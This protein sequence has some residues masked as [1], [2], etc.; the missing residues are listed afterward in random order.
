MYHILYIPKIVMG[1]KVTL[2]VFGRSLLL[3]SKCRF[4]HLFERSI[5]L[6]GK[7]RLCRSVAV[8]SNMLTA[9]SCEGSLI[10]LCTYAQNNIVSLLQRL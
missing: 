4:M 10:R 1:E 2:K 6:N 5:S 9:S 8:T 3:A 7:S